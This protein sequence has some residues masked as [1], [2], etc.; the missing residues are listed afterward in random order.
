[1]FKLEDYQ[2]N[3]RDDKGKPFMVRCSCCGLE[4]HAMAVAT[5]GCAWCGWH[6]GLC[7]KFFKDSC[8]DCPMTECRIRDAYLIKGY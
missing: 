6:E 1:M 4:N 2:E 7:Q 3:F 5:G 8:V